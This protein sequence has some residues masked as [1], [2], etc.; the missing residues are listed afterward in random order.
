MPSSSRLYN[1]ARAYHDELVE[2]RGVLVLRKLDVRALL[3][4]LVLVQGEVLVDV[5]GVIQPAHRAFIT[6][7]ASLTRFITPTL[8][9]A[10]VTC[11]FIGGIG[12]PSTTNMPF[13][14]SRT[15]C[16]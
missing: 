2:L 15:V 6:P 12:S 8:F 10:P 5:D 3:V 16:G 1:A 4:D 7:L 11:F 13:M 9:S 14:R